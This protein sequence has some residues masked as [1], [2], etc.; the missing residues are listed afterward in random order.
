MVKLSY[1][2]LRLL[3]SVLESSV[4]NRNYSSYFKEKLTLTKE[5][6]FL[7]NHWKARN[8]RTSAGFLGTTA[9][10]S[11]PASAPSEWLL[12]LPSTSL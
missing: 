5:I 10:N 12:L 6:S 7:Q 4:A 11:I 2:C 8:S 3:M 9:E 1:V